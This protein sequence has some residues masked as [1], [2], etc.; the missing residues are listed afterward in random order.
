VCGEF[1]L[2]SLHRHFLS[3]ILPQTD[4]AVHLRVVIICTCLLLLLIY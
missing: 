1:L 4:T 3:L 2:D